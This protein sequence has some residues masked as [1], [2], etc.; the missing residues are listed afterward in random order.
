MKRRLPFSLGKSVQT[1][2]FFSG[3]AAYHPINVAIAI[4]I[5]G[6]FDLISSPC[7]LHTP[8]SGSVQYAHDS[9]AKSPNANGV[10]VPEESKDVL[11]AA[12]ERPERS[13]EKEE[14]CSP[15][16]AGIC[17]RFPTHE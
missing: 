8:I 10:S 2:G 17:R 7:L 5:E 3:I 4:S 12:R 16:F 1:E 15:G 13:G 9:N 6:F 14:K 11:G